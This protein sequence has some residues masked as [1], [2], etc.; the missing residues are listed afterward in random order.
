[1][2]NNFFVQNANESGSH[3]SHAGLNSSGESGPAGQYP[4]GAVNTSQ[5]SGNQVSGG[6]TSSSLEA[7]VISDGV[8]VSAILQ[9]SDA[10]IKPEYRPMKNFS[11][12]MIKDARIV[13]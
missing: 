3:H 13:D 12:N 11:E 2:T 6:N 5:L 8:P 4:A 9:T 7:S 1:M 10:S